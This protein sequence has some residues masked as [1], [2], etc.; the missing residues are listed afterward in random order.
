M[1]LTVYLHPDRGPI[2]P[3]DLNLLALFET[4][5]PPAG[6][7]LTDAHLRRLED[8]IRAR[9]PHV[10]PETNR[11]GLKRIYANFLT[12][13]RFD[14]VVLRVAGTIEAEDESGEVVERYKAEITRWAEENRRLKGEVRELER[15]HAGLE[16]LVE[17]TGRELEARDQLR[18]EVGDLRGELKLT[19]AERDR[20]RT[21]AD[22]L[23]ATL[24]RQTTPDRREEPGEP[25]GD[26]IPF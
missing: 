21:R 6:E 11:R 10:R 22:G 12:A 1:R 9:Y 5:T 20:E 17:Q 8:A 2:S 14:G 25:P 24:E 3:V 7:D 16:A 4:V 18:R 23:Q 19:R 15:V 26:H 13:Y